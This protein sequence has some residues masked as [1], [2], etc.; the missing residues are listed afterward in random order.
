MAAEIAMMA[1]MAVMV[2][3]IAAAMYD[4]RPVEYL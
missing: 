1:V 2:G 4:P 3:L